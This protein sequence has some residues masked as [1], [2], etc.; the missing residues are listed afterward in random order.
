MRQENIRKNQ[1]LMAALNIPSIVQSVITTTTEQKQNKKNNKN[2]KKT[3]QP[4]V[5]RRSQRQRGQAPNPSM[6][7]PLFSEQFTQPDR[8]EGDI[9]IEPIHEHES[10]EEKD[11]DDDDDDKDKDNDDDDEGNE[12]SNN[13]ST[14]STTTITAGTSKTGK[15][16]DKKSDGNDDG[17]TEKKNM[18]LTHDQFLD[19][20]VT[21]QRKYK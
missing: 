11:N 21:T 15:A 1:E 5:L 6:L 19:E 10:G 8:I 9:P 13:I 20:V 2:I 14:S 3:E 7:P 18:T 4:L 16:T 17:E 12:R